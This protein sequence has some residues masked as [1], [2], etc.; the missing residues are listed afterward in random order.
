MIVA[1]K[2]RAAAGRKIDRKLILRQWLN[3]REANDLSSRSGTAS[4]INDA[5]QG[6][7]RM[8]VRLDYQAGTLVREK[9][10]LIADIMRSHE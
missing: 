6:C 3:W 1:L 7:P 10:L 2:S 8:D 4:G 5:W 9:I